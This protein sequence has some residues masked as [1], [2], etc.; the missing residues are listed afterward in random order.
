MRQTFPQQQDGRLYLT[1][2]GQETEIMYK[3]GYDL[4]HFVMFQLL[5]DPK[6][7]TELRGMYQRYL[8]TVARHGFCALMGGLDYR[9][10]L[11]WARLL[12]YSA[13]GLAEMQLR[14]ID[15]LRDTARPYQG[16]IEEILIVGCI[17]P[18]GDA[19]E[20]NRD[21]TVDEAQEYHSAQLTT[22]KEAEVDLASAM[23]FNSVAEAVGVS[24]AAAEVGLPV[25]VG[26]TLDGDHRLHSGPSLREAV[27]AVDAQ[28]GDDRPDFYGINCS[29]PFEFEPALEPGGW[30]E[31]VRSLRPNAAAME[32]VALCTLGHLEEGDPVELG[33]LAGDL[34]RRYPH[35]DVWGGCC[36]TW[37]KHLE[38]IARNVKAVRTP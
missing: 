18:R 6:A 14:A 3:F 13:E 27:L 17:G 25:C 5:D 36:G 29:H 15:F 35:L 19:Y 34:A 20:L 16:R 38:E 26:F 7:V 10:S 33:T 11:D 30:I 23:T 21:I 24:R 22:L 31:R 8:D 2:G 4:P 28:A 9:A 37:E 12:G 32:K 1:E